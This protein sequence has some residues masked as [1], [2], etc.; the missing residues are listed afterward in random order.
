MKRGA[1][2]KGKGRRRDEM[3]AK[4]ISTGAERR[5]TVLSKSVLGTGWPDV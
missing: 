1:K 4:A 2:L 5:S 3:K